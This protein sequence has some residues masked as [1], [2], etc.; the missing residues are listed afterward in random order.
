MWT[1][2]VRTVGPRTGAG[3]LLLAAWPVRLVFVAIAGATLAFAFATGQPMIGLAALFLFA[4]DLL[5][6]WGSFAI[7]ELGHA[8]VLMN[9]HGV[10]AVTLE[11]SLLRLSITPH[12][13]IRGRDA[14][15]AAAFGPACCIAIGV[16]LWLAVPH[17]FLHVWYLGHAIFLLPV[18]GDG[19]TLAASARRWNDRIL[20]CPASDCE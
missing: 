13:S 19:R 17:L 6:L 14:F 1:A 15:L 10:S 9:A 2:T 11:R 16:G 18:F 7:H 20:L 12:G 4:H 8:V 5:G 3:W